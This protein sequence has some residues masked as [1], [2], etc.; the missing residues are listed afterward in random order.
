MKHTTVET[1]IQQLYNCS[2]VEFLQK[3][4][5]KKMDTHDIATEIN[6]SV[7]N[8]RRIARKHQ[9]TFYQPKPVSLLAHKKEFSLQSLNI[10][11]CL[12]RRWS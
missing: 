2:I 6:C 5:D 12:S 8:L 11:N 3:C 9:F 10:N 4:V 1:R 7:S